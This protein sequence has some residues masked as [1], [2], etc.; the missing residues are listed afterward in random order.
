VDRDPNG[1]VDGRI[2]WRGI[3]QAK[4]QAVRHGDSSE[5]KAL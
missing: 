1:V 3:L 5:I 4:A 2:T